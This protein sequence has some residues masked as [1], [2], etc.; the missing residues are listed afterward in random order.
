[1]VPA[2]VE[3][4]LAAKGFPPELFRNIYLATIGAE[5][6]FELPCLLV[7]FAHY[8]VVN[9]DVRLDAI[10]SEWVRARLL[11]EWSMVTH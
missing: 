10:S 8:A 6:A 7:L 4:D 1:M 3:A 2:H 11:T 9:G 5:D